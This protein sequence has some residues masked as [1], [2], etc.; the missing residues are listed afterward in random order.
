MTREGPYLI[1]GEKG[2]LVALTLHRFY[3]LKLVHPLLYDDDA[4]NDIKRIFLIVG[5]KI[6]DGRSYGH[7]W[8]LNF[9]PFPHTNATGFRSLVLDCARVSTD[10]EI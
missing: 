10:V 5:S 1:F 4:A 3:V 7:T 9:A 2:K 8:I 6:L